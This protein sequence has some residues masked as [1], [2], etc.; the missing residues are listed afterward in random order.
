MNLL[1][2]DIDEINGFVGVAPY[3]PFAQFGAEGPDAFR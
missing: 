1:A 2:L 3:R